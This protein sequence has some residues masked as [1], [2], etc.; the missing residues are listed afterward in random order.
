MVLIECF[1]VQLFQL[2]LSCKGLFNDAAELVF[3]VLR[4]NVTKETLIR[5][6]AT[7]EVRRKTG[8][9]DA[10]RKPRCA[11]LRC[12]LLHCSLWMASSNKRGKCR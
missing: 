9:L 8:V 7:Q 1:E 12:A 10:D 6:K 4:Q 11:L 5:K 2:Q 3:K